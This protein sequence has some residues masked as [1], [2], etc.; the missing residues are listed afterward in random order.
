MDQA[1]LLVKLQDTDIALTRARK[2]LDEMP[3]KTAILE[4]RKRIRDLEGLRAKTHAA[5]EA[6]DRSATRHEDE[7]ATLSGKIDSEQT[8]VMSGEVTN[9]KEVANITRELDSLKRQKDKLENGILD[10]M[11][12]RE[13]VAEQRAKVDRALG[14]ARAKEEALIK[15]FQAKGT[16]I[17]RQIERLT[18]ERSAAARAMEVDLLLCYEELREAKHGVGAGVLQAETCSA[19]RMELPSDKVAELVCGPP[20][21]ICPTCHRLLVISLP[22]EEAGG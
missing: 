14:V 22:S 12:K 2:R 4:Q 18:A 20:I 16:E 15:D 6:V 5:W 10:E 3:E 19:C 17:T 21:G 11:E 1:D 13:T 7:A 9:A 8:K